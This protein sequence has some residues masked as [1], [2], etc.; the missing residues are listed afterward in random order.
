MEE[1]KLG[2][3]RNRDRETCTRIEEISEIVTALVQNDGCKQVCAFYRTHV[4]VK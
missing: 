3:E 1:A 2:R 4:I